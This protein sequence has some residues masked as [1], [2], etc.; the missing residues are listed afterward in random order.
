MG[1]NFSLET[2]YPDWFSSVPSGELSDI[3]LKLGHNC[4]LPDPFQFII[5]FSPYH[6]IVLVTE[7]W[8][9]INCLFN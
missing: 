9:E 3:T 6:S 1:S 7:K 5:H 8:N 4:Y 2:G